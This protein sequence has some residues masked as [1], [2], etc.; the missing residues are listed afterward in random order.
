MRVFV[1]TY[2]RFNS[3][4][5]PIELEKSGADYLVLCHTPEQRDQFIAAGRVKPDRLVATLVP[6]GLAFNRNA[7]LDMMQP[8]EWAVFLVDD[9]LKCTELDC[10]DQQT[11]GVLPVKQ[12]R[13]TTLWNRR[14]RNEVPMQKF[15]QRAEEAAAEAERRGLALAGF[16]GNDNALFRKV[17]FKT[18]TLADGRAWVVK[19]TH[20]RFDA[21]AQMVDDVAWT[22]ANLV[23]FGGVLVNQWI[24]PYC[25]R[26]T[27][28][29]F[30]SKE[31]R[32]PQ[33]LKECAYLVQKYKGLVKYAQKPGW[34]AGSHIKIIPV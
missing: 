33:K 15:L 6:K 29:S 4:T 2:D 11:T 19:K 5:T 27:S 23:E 22:L 25:S 18:W 9:W 12:G 7:A 10:Y 24:L 3:I 32:L 13:S 28:G 17:K 1:F 31:Q 20:L 21:N 14:F 8:G 30:G 34:P 16:A 26:Y